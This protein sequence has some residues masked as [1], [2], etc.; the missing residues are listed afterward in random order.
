MWG[1]A[2]DRAGIAN[3][4]QEECK[5]M[6]TPRSHL[7]L[8]SQCWAGAKCKLC[9]TLASPLSP[10]GREK[11]R[12]KGQKLLHLSTPVKSSVEPLG[13]MHTQQSKVCWGW[14]R[15]ELS[16]L[17][18]ESWGHRQSVRVRPRMSS[19]AASRTGGWTMGQGDEQVWKRSGKSVVVRGGTSIFAPSKLLT[20]WQLDIQVGI[21]E[22]GWASHWDLLRQVG[23]GKADLSCQHGNGS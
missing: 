13:W 20:S 17:H 14:R 21:R 4:S 15:N 23:A 18:N 3:E 5:D 6:W 19:P 11:Q 22:T 16:V 10:G 8:R 7:L 12:G 1:D 9:A 2:W